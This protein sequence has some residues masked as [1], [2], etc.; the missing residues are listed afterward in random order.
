M[1]DDD[2]KWLAQVKSAPPDRLG[3][4]LGECAARGDDWRV[5]TLVDLGADIDHNGGI[6][7]CMAAGGGHLSLIEKLIARG[8]DFEA[9]KDDALAEAAARG[10]E[11]A[12]RLLIEKGAQAA[13]EDSVCLFL[14]VQ[15]DKPAVVQAL[16]EGG[17]GV[18]AH[19][20]ALM[21]IALAHGHAE[22]ARVLLDN[23]ADPRCRHRGMNAYEWAAQIGLTGFSKIL[24][25]R[26]NT[27]YDKTDVFM[28]P[29]FFRRFDAAALK[30]DMPDKPGH[31]GLHL[32]ALA[33]CFDVVR[34]IF[35]AA[36]GARLMPEDLLK[37]TPGR[38]SALALLGRTG[39][40]SIAFD[41]RLWQGRKAEAAALFEKIP[42]GYRPQVD[43]AALA[44]ALD[45]TALHGKAPKPGLRLKPPGR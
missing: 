18:Q 33:G 44:A 28:S 17:A 40:L 34:D 22:V 15:N 37:E 7:L 43:I 21:C 13:H 30:Q 26:K 1:D 41:P 42:S 9:C 39:Q 35:L 16:L 4:R 8:I 23:G 25:D 14:A 36:P 10:Q 38:E 2:E 45:Q 20:G 29:G 31:T 3:D 12:V 5:T 19:D 24:R 32:A 11:K 27:A 6:A